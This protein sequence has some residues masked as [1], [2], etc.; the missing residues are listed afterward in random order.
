MFTG[1]SSL[2]HPK[3]AAE[4]R[5]E[6]LGLHRQRRRVTLRGEE[7]SLFR[8]LPPMT[9]CWQIRADLDGGVVT[10]RVDR[11]QE[12]NPALGVV[13]IAD[14]RERGRIGR[15][16]ELENPFARPRVLSQEASARTPPKRDPIG[17]RSMR[18]EKPIKA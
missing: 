5:Y 15:T 2:V 10:V 4:P 18:A 6:K 9:R 7:M 1:G 14:P 8:Q 17:E 16:E 12:P 3:R 13:R 11:E